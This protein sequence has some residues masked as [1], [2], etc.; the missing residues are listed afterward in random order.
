MKASAFTYA[1]KALFLKQGA[2]GVP[3]R[4]W[5]LED[6]AERIKAGKPAPAKRGHYRKREG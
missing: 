1:Q 5:S 4:L 6:F 3:D 2:D